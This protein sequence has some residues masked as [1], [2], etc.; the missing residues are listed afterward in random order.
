MAT[1]VATDLTALDRVGMSVAI[2]YELARLRSDAP[3]IDARSQGRDGLGAPLVFDVS[4][5]K[6][7]RAAVE[8][9]PDARAVFERLWSLGVDRDW[10]GFDIL[11]LDPVDHGLGRMIELKSSGVHAV[12]QSMTWNEW[13]SAR[14]SD[15]R[16]S[17][18]LYLVGNPP[19][20]PLQMRVPSSRPSKTRSARCSARRSRSRS[21]VAPSASTS[22]TSR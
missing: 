15:L 3:D 10:P 21:A 5:P 7:V 14:A 8:S 17:F 4:G 12:T 13:K 1:L 16:A 9:S 2:R 18:W 6:A 20:G 19:L 22:D 11:T